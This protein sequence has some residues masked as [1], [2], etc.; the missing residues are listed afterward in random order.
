MHECGVDEP[1]PTCPTLEQWLDRAA[2]AVQ[3]SLRSVLADRPSVAEIVEALSR[4]RKAAIEVYET[5][6]FPM[7]AGLEQLYIA[8]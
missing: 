2:E 6:A 8:A 5:K 7:L 3:E 1:G 4:T